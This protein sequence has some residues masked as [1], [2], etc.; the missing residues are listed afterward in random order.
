MK[1]FG[2]EPGLAWVASVS[3]VACTTKAP[4]TPF[5]F[6]EGQPKDLLGLFVTYILSAQLCPLCDPWTVAHGQ[7][8]E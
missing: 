5:A 2:D 4:C 7:S 8:L 3:D 6:P 1:F